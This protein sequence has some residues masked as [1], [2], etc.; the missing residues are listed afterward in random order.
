MCRHWETEIRL[1]NLA[2]SQQ[3]NT[4]L[5]RVKLDQSFMAKGSKKTQGNILWRGNFGRED[6][7]FDKGQLISF[8]ARV[9]QDLG[10][11][12]WMGPGAQAGLKDQNIQDHR[13]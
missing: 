12:N 3:H 1:E 6:T 13:V 7:L 2:W 11:R 9:R 5:V 4:N 10:W 8:L